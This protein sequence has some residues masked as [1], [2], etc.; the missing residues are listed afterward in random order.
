MLPLQRRARSRDSTA[1]GAFYRCDF[2]G[3]YRKAAERARTRADRDVRR[4]ATA[5]D[6]HAANVRDVVTRV[7]GVPLPT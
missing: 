4:I 3:P 5:G 2:F 7:E 6:Q 1:T